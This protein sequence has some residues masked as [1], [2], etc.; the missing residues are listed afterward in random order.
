MGLEELVVGL[1]Q[2][3]GGHVAGGGDAERALT[4]KR[5]TEQGQH[6]DDRV[7]GLVYRLAVDVL[8]H[9]VGAAAHCQEGG[10][11]DPRGL[12]RDVDRGVTEA[13]DQHPLARQHVRLAVVVHVDLLAAEL[14]RPGKPGSGH[15]GSQWSPS[16]TITAR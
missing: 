3:V 13:Q 9:H 15:L 12:D 14:V 11:G 16:A 2:A 8:R 4:K 6:R 5:W 10:V 7:A 1:G